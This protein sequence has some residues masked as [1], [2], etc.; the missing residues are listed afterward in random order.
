M[1]SCV[2]LLPSAVG[3]AIAVI[4]IINSAADFRI[5][6]INLVNDLRAH[7]VFLSF[8]GFKFYVV[9]LTPLSNK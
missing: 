3:G 5:A 1:I 4:V 9:V 6:I 7:F 8:Y 2:A